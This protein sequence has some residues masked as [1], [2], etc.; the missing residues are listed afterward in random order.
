E[1]PAR[2][3]SHF[4]RTCGKCFRSET[5][6]IVMTGALAPSPLLMPMFSSAAMQAIVDDGVRLQRMLDFEAALAR[7]QAAVGGIP[8]EAVD[9]I[10]A[11]AK[12]DRFDVAAI[13]AAA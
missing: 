3:G 2:T 8:P 1:A 4:G 13:A 12:I 7:A 11:A 9:P 5:S 6:A 10:V